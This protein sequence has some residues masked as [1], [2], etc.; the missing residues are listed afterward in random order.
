MIFAFTI[1]KNNQS[2]PTTAFLGV[3]CGSHGGE[4]KDACLLNEY[5]V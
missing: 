2:K 4:Y 5:A 1:I 3:I